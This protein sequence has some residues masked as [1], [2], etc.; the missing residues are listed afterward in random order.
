MEKEIKINNSLHNI[1]ETSIETAMALKNTKSIFRNKLHSEFYN[2]LFLEYY[3]SDLKIFPYVSLKSFIDSN[4]IRKKLTFFE[5]NF[6][7]LLK[8]K[9]LITSNQYNEE[10]P[11]IAIEFLKSTYTEIDLLKEKILK[12]VEIE[13]I[14]VNPKDEI[15]LTHHRNIEGNEIFGNLSKYQKNLKNTLL[16]N[17]NINLL[18]SLLKSDGIME[19][20]K[21]SDLLSKGIIFY[22]KPVFLG[23]LEELPKQLF[24]FNFNSFFILGNYIISKEILNSNGIEIE[25]ILF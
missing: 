16:N 6:F 17:E 9:F 2:S 5:Y 12:L 3:N 4:F 19:E 14:R 8:V 13:M 10:K 20:K 15:D 25:E 1:S 7:K 23:S 21:F 24:Y 22:K 18:K 11:I